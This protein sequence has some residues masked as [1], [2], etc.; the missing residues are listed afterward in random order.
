MGATLLPSAPVLDELQ[1]GTL[2]AQRIDQPSISRT[3]V[4]CY[5][6]NIPL[7]NAATAISRLVR[8]VSE[9][10][11]VDGLWPGATPI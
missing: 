4:L 3:V 8:Q 1:R 11:C 10:L 2:R 7:T 5:S 6:R 9:T